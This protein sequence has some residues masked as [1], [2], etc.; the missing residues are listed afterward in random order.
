MRRPLATRVIRSPGKESRSAGRP[1]RGVLPRYVA[2]G[3]AKKV[4]RCI[5]VGDH[6]PEI[7]CGRVILDFNVEGKLVGVEVIG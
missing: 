1:T 2:I 3:D 4:S 7:E 5:D 6:V